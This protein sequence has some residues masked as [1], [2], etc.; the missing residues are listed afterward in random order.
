MLQ[1]IRDRLVGWVAWGI[2]IL[3]GVPFAIIGITDFGTPARVIPVAEVGD[4][5]IDQE[6]YQRRYQLRRQN[7]QQQLEDRYNPDLFDPQLRKQ[8]VNMLVEEALLRV[9]AE[10]NNIHISDNE[11]ALIIQSDSSFQKDGRFDFNEYRA[12]IGQEGFTPDR[13]EQFLRRE[14]ILTT[15]PRMVRASSFATHGEAKRLNDLAAHKRV[16]R[17]AVVGRD[18]SPDDVNISEDDARS[19]YD[20]HQN[21]FERP[22]QIKLEYL[23]V[24]ASRLADRVEITEDALRRYY[25][26]HSERYIVDEQRKS[27]HI[28]IALPEGESLENSAEALE[29]FNAVKD[30]L[31]AG[32][33]FAELARQYSDDPG[34]ASA[35]GDLGQVSR[36]MMVKPF[37][38]ALFAMGEAGEISEPVLTSF[39]Y[40]FIRLDEII[41]RQEQSFDEVRQ[42]LEEGYAE[43]ESVNLFYDV[44]E[45]MAELS[46]EN[47]DSLV[48]VSEALGIPLQTTD[49]L[50]RENDMPVI[51]ADDEANVEANPDVLREAF[52]ERL[53]AGDNSDPVEIDKNDVVIIRVVDYREAV[54]LPFDD[55][56]EQAL[57]SARNAAIDTKIREFALEL[58]EN[59][60]GGGSFEEL[61]EQHGLMLETPE[62][63]GRDNL[64][65]PAGM[66]PQVFKMPVPAG[67][68]IS[69]TVVSL[70]DGSY[71]VIALDKIMLPEAANELLVR[72]LSQRYAARAAQ[73]VV[74]AM[75]EAA[76]VVIHEDRL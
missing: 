70:S 52:S 39:G 55:V 65:L 27:S 24:S 67:D 43:Q 57:S 7:V 30:K 19:Y 13:Y 22:E 32:E 62:P 14:R 8:V 46:Y 29:K 6:E 18:F 41:E 60:R 23:R 12:R 74:T 47:Q 42:E 66:L 59:V 50:G 38:T 68:D 10:D 25:E 51:D 54:V 3:I 76:D 4:I 2:V 35:G 71:G 21:Q 11:L 34:S 48:P 1:S 53:R 36:G 45:H 75:R 56:T 37:E 40:H 44:S 63:I 64:S 17:Y 15:L 33:D 73:S 26:E 61:V 28:L 9:F 20:S 31:A 5:S 49:W 58:A 16:I 72:E 69:V